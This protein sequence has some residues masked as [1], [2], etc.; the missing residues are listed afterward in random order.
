M[1]VE[2]SNSLGMKL[3]LI[4]PGEF[5]MG[6]PDSDSYARD[7][8]K[9][10]HAVRHTK[11]FYAGI[12]EVTVA[13]FRAFV[14][15]TGYVTDAEQEGAGSWLLIDLPGKGRNPDWNWRTP[16]FEQTDGHPVCCV[17]WRDA[18]RF[19]AWLSVKEKQLYHLPTEAQWEYACRAGT[20]TPYHFG[21]QLDAAATHV[22]AKGTAAAGS[23]AANAFGLHD[24]HGNVYEW[25]QDGRRDFEQALAIDPVGPIGKG[26][27]RLVRGGAWSS[28]PN[29]RNMAA[30]AAARAVTCAADRPFHGL[31]FRVILVP[32]VPKQ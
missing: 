22:R 14:E 27:E 24:M 11:P 8:E 20:A 23:Y 31:G 18:E 7:R 1:T 30:R 17:S 32:E 28:T 21:D 2:I 3:R 26:V 29:S 4:P 12:H 13:Q 9:P 10:Q 19:C 16:G 15:A 6:S 25:C 5:L